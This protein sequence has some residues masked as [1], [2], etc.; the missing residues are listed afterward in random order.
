MPYTISWLVEKYVILSRTIGD[1]AYEDLEGYNAAIL[2]LLDDGEAPVHLVR[3]VSQQ[4]D[5]PF[6]PIAVRRALTYLHHAKLGLIVAYGTA[7]KSSIFGKLLTSLAGVRMRFV[8]DHADAL[9]VLAAE[10]V[11]LRVLIPDDGA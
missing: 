1:I 2:A 5:F 6:D 11:R 4:G 7:R 9:R 10:D 8:R 3:D